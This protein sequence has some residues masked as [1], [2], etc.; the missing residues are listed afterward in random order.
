MRKQKKP[1]KKVYVLNGRCTPEGCV[2]AVFSSMKKAQDAIE[3]LIE[4]DTFYNQCPHTL[5]IDVF[6][7]NEERVTDDGKSD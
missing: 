1:M 4:N 2:V 6:E 7:L 3:W 5:W